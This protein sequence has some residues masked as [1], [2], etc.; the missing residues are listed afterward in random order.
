MNAYPELFRA[1][2]GACRPEVRPALAAAQLVNGTGAFQRITDEGVS[3]LDQLPA[4]TSPYDNL[5]IELGKISDSSHNSHYA[6]VLISQMRINDYPD[7]IT[8]EI[9]TN[10][11]KQGTDIG[12][13]LAFH[14]I[15]D[16]LPLKLFNNLGR[17]DVMLDSH[18]SIVR[19]TGAPISQYMD[20]AINPELKAAI[21]KERAWFFKAVGNA[22]PEIACNAM[23]TD[24]VC[25]SLLVLGM[26]HCKN[27]ELY[28][29][30]MSS[31]QLRHR[32]K[33]NRPSERF[34]SLRVTGKGARVGADA[35]RV[36]SGQ[37][38]ALH[39][40]RGHFRT[41]TDDAPLFGRITGTFWVDPHIRGSRGVGKVDKLYTIDSAMPIPDKGAE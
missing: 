17:A 23:L 19:L 40:C 28:E 8:S 16:T 35:L 11:R 38:N 5:W 39:W 14:V 29:R 13:H 34:Y 32:Q 33:H 30:P 21:N 22:D 24:F 9:Q 26:L 6:G 1:V 31:K 15:S 10:L 4:F 2:L 12:W 36:P 3:I 25:S 20:V 27:V 41:Y 7:A 37:R 18:G